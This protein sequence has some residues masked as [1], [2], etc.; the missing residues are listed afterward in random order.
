MKKVIKFTI[1][2]I[3]ADVLICILYY[4]EVK[5]FIDNPEPIE[6]PEAVIVFF[7]DYDERN[8][9]LL[10]TSIQRLDHAI[11]LYDS[12]NCKSIVCVGGN[13]PNRH[14]KGSK[15]SCDYLI[16]KGIDPDVLFFDTLSFDTKTNWIEAKKIVEQNNFSK[17]ICVS[18]PLHLYRISKISGENDVY[19]ST[20]TVYYSSIV[21]YFNLFIN[22]N[23]ELFVWIL[24]TLIPEKTYIKLLKCFRN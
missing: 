19:Y 17:I 22:I 3:I 1:I 20:Y 6:N 14:F 2:L 11:K 13:R 24:Y 10:E 4:S 9:C 18:S 12:L 8:H 5:E 21:D 15:I 23:K 16:K 7:G